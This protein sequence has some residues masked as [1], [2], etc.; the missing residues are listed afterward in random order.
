MDYF[1]A[2][3]ALIGLVV[4]IHLTGKIIQ[5]KTILLPLGIETFLYLI[6]FTCLFFVIIL[7]RDN[8]SFDTRGDEYLT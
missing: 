7:P 2:N 6:F 8:P 1:R 4:G 3:F 5:Y